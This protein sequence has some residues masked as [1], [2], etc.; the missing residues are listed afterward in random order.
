MPY[1]KNDVVGEEEFFCIVENA[2][3]DSYD[4]DN[5]LAESCEEDHLL[6]IDHTICL[7]LE[8]N[9]DFEFCEILNKE[10]NNC[11]KCKE[12][13]GLVYVSDIDAFACTKTMVTIP[14]CVELEYE[15]NEWEEP[16]CRECEHYFEL[17]DNNRGC[18]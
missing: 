8:D 9:P 2:K 17:H 12:N 3:V 16:I 7:D 5:N 14:H 10:A 1:D 4:F 6:N 18:V 11:I 15:H 13:Y